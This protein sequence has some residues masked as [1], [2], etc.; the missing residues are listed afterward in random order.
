MGGGRRAEGDGPQR[1]A[2]ALGREPGGMAP[3][4]CRSSVPRLLETVDNTGHPEAGPQSVSFSPATLIEAGNLAPIQ[5][6]HVCLG[7]RP[8]HLPPWFSRLRLSSQ[9]NAMVPNRHTRL[10]TSPTSPVHDRT[11][12]AKGWDGR[13]PRGGRGAAAATPQPLAWQGYQLSHKHRTAT[14]SCRKTLKLLPL[15]I[16]CLIPTTVQTVNGVLEMHFLPVDPIDATCNLDVSQQR[17]QIRRV[18]NAQSKPPSP[19][20]PPAAHCLAGTG[21]D[22][23][24]AARLF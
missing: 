17:Q 1:A 7:R 2:A 12:T 16:S 10:S 3:W 15:R 6:T 21:G 24:L 22:L 5:D 14:Q 18:S 8:P 4:L 11:L 23:P 19:P 20:T 13:D 9:N